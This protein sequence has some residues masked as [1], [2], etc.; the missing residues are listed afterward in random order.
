MKL[1]KYY[2]ISNFELIMVIFQ[3]LI[4]KRIE[5]LVLDKNIKY[6]EDFKKYLICLGLRSNYISIKFGKLISFIDITVEAFFFFF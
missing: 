2:N 5:S 6:F 4:L 1:Q 3:K